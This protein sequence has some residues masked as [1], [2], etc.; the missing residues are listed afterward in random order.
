MEKMDAGEPVGTDAEEIQYDMPLRSDRSFCSVL[1]YRTQYVMKNSKV[2]SANTVVLEDNFHYD[3][4]DAKYLYLSMSH[5]DT[6][7]TTAFGIIS[8]NPKKRV[9]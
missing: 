5:D 1:S 7:T 3:H 6:G 9:A 8:L 4:S 2:Y